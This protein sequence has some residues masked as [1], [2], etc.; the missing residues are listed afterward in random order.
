[1]KG[2]GCYV[3]VVSWVR[4]RTRSCRSTRSQVLD[5]HRATSG[6][7][8]QLLVQPLLVLE[9]K[10]D[11]LHNF[12]ISVHQCSGSGSTNVERDLQV[13]NLREK[14]PL[15]GL[16]WIKLNVP[17]CKNNNRLKPFYEELDKDPQ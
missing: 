10:M 2:R 4:L 13:K 14:H 17:E 12:E 9:K 8:G 15:I 11:I 3:L 5:G 7:W 16:E 6:S 1:M